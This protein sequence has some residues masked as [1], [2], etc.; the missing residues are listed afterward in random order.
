MAQS[1]ADKK[2]IKSLLKEAQF[3]LDGEDYFK[4]WQ[5][6]RQVLN[7]APKN[8]QVGVNDAIC[9]FKLNYGLDSALLLA[10]N[11]SASKQNDAKFYLAKIKHQ[12]KLFD[13]A[14]TLL[15]AYLLIKPT[16]RLHSNDETYYLMNCCISGKA[17]VANP[18]RVEISNMGP[19]INTKYDDYVPVISPDE[20]ALYFTSKREGSVGNKIN[21][22][23]A[24]FEDVYVSYKLNGS[25]K[26]AENMGAP[27]NSETNDACVAIS[28]DGQRMIIYRTAK[29]QLTGDLYLSQM[30]KQNTWEAPQIMSDAINSPYIETSACFSNDSSEIFFSSDRPGGYGGKDLYRIKKLPNGKWSVP[31]NL[32]ANI[33]TK[34]DEDAPFL[35][36]DGVTLYFSSKGHNS[37]GEYDVFKGVY[38][39]DIHQFSKAEN[40]GY[41]INDVGNDIFFVLNV[42]GQTGY[43]SSIKEETYG[44]LDLYQIDTRFGYNDLKVTSGITRINDVPAKVRITLVDKESSQINGNY[45][46][47]PSTGKFILV[48]NPLRTYRALVEA[49]GCLPQE[50]EIKPLAQDPNIMHLEINLQTNNAQ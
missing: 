39:S 49:P 8:E 31:M 28:A 15:E 37:M 2:K 45:Y 35:H 46:S 13:E 18:R 22:D 10:D 38:D 17:L 44:G 21:G 4:S 47:N 30:G 27:I 23:H 16:K 34:Y 9:V 43:Y 1:K 14:Y 19:N 11:L 20:S 42:D 6:Y 41:P 48:I 32:G 36:P 7:L 26:A 5:S 3:Y 25:W 24:Y 50:L 33:N 12:Q 40:L 29:D